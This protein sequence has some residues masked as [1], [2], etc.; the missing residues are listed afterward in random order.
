[1]QAE[2]AQNKVSDC[3]EVINFCKADLKYVD[4]GMYLFTDNTLSHHLQKDK[5]VRAI[6]LSKQGKVVYALLP[7]E[8]PMLH[9]KDKDY[10]EY[11]PQILVDDSYM[12]CIKRMPLLRTLMNA[13]FYVKDINQALEEAKLPKLQGRYWSWDISRPY[14][15]Y[16]PEIGDKSLI[17]KGCS[18]KVRFILEVRLK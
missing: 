3:P 8:Q 9:E 5:T 17:T 12:R 2:G 10:R 7:E 15:M 16:D 13:H 11:A 14:F 1:M 18:A 4:T 6:V